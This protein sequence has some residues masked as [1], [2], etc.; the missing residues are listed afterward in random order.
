MTP[1][2]HWEK[3]AKAADGGRHDETAAHAGA[4]LRGLAVVRRAEVVAQLVRHDEGGDGGAVGR[5][6]S[7]TPRSTAQAEFT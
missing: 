7:D 5:S 4:A 6:L 1:M 3:L 2:L